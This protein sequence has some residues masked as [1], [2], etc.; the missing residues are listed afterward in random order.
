MRRAL[1]IAVVLFTL[2]QFGWTC[3]ERRLFSVLAV[4]SPLPPAEPQSTGRVILDETP[5]GLGQ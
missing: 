3:I 2:S 1:T 4:Q 5:Q